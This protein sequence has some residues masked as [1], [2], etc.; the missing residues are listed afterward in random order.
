MTIVIE[1][2]DAE[3]VEAL[4]KELESTKIKRAALLV[5]GGVDSF[6]ISNMPADDAKKDVAVDYSQ[7]GEM[8]ATGEWKDGKVHLH[9]TFGIEGDV[10][11]AGHL[12]AAEVKTHFA[13]VYVTEAGALRKRTGKVWA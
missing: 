9:A 7:P 2:R 10:A 13:N 6:R 5:V 1:I 12:H 8:L 3:L 11:R 4:Q